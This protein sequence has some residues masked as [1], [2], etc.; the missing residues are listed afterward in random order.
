MHKKLSTV[1]VSM[2]VPASTLKFQANPKNEN[3]RLCGVVAS[4]CLAPV[5]NHI[6][7]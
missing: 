1:T 4:M 2:R 6:I 5:P 7:F 3:R